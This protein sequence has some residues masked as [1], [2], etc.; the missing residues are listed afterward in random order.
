MR[1]R[2]FTFAI[3]AAFVAFSAPALAQTSNGKATTAAPTYANGAIAPLSLDTAG[4]MRVNCVSGCAGSGGTD[5]VNIT[6]V[7]GNAVTTTI[8]ISGSVTTSGTATV[9]GTVGVSSLPALVAGTAN[10]GKVDVNTLPALPTGANTIGKVDINSPLPALAAGTNTIGGAI[11]IPATTTAGT[12]SHSAI[13]PANT[14]AVVVKASA[15]TV[16]ELS[17]Y[18]ISTTTTAY[19][20]IYDGLSIICGAGTPVARYLIPFASTGGAGSNV[21]IPL[22]K[23]FAT[24]ITYCVTAGIA[25]ADST[26]VAANTALINIT[27][28]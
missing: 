27:Y 15:G 16:Y 10:I 28:K 14:T 25:D 1:K 19:L 4:N 11:A 20:K 12:N 3:I 18:N 24:A 8:P 5:P 23:S 13:Q 2:S 9:S 26:A 7:G 22:G 21:T 6:E 17:L